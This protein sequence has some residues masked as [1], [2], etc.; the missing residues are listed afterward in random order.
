MALE[1][2]INILSSVALFEAFTH[3]Q[4]RLMAFGAERLHIA[5]DQAIYREGETADCAYIVLAGRVGLLKEAES[6][7]RTTLRSVR[8]G[9]ILG[10]LALISSS[11][12]LTSA[13][14]ETDVEVLRIGHSLFHR[15][16]EEYPD[17]AVALHD[18]IGRQLTDLVRRIERLS[19]H[20][21][22]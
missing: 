9:S 14:A 12:R 21:E 22:R 7:E 8:S 3:D 5:K 11:R 16:L 20:F 2:D 19:R 17:L 10:E 15:I 13:V 6:G 4:L 1:D 18:Q